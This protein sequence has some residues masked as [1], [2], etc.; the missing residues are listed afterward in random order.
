MRP[1]S[2]PDLRWRSGRIPALPYPPPQANRLYGRRGGKRVKRSASILENKAL[3]PGGLG[4]EPPGGLRALSR[5]PM[6]KEVGR[7]A[8]TQPLVWA[9]VIVK[10]EVMVERRE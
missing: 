2:I 7:L 8:I 1:P 5:E 10:V 3:N 9:L 6:W 4:A